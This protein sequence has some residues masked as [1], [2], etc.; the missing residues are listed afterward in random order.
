[1][2]EL[3]EI[4]KLIDELTRHHAAACKARIKDMTDEVLKRAV[5]DSSAELLDA[6]RLKVSLVQSQ[7]QQASQEQ[8]EKYRLQKAKEAKELIDRNHRTKRLFAA[9]DVI[10]REFLGNYPGR[11]DVAPLHVELDRIKAQLINERN[12]AKGKTGLKI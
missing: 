2:N 6:K 4:D 11:M 5:T 10:V 9:L 3:A 8:A 1:M 7:R 12:A